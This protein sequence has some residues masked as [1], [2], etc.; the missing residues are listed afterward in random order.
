LRN[1]YQKQVLETVAPA[2]SKIIWCF[3]FSRPY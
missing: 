2:S 3:I 1:P